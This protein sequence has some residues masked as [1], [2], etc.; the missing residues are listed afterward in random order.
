MG[1]LQL[2][3][4]SSEVSDS[5]KRQAIRN[6][7]CTLAETYLRAPQKIHKRR[8]ESMVVIAQR[9]FKWIVCARRPL[10]MAELKV[11]INLTER[12]D[13]ID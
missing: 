13:L 9:I 4:I 5:A 1:A 3:D 11:D 8:N 12:N 6:I 2:A 10:F 7:P